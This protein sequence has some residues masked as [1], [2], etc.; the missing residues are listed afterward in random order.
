MTAE[1]EFFLRVAAFALG[2]IGLLAFFRSIVRKGWLNTRERDA[3]AMCVARIVVAA[4]VPVARRRRTYRDVQRLM[5]WAFPAYSFGLVI[6]WFLLV[7]S[8]FALMIRAVEADRTLFRAFIASGSALA[9][10]GFDS[11]TT[12]PGR[13]IAI[14]EGA[15]GLGIVV[16][17][18]TFIPGY[19]TA[20]Q[21]REDKVG[22]LYARAGPS[23]TAFNLIRWCWRA[24]KADDLTELWT[25]GE[26]W[27]RGIFE[28]HSV[29]PFLAF[30]PSIYE[31]GNWIR[32]AATLLDATSFAISSV[33]SPHVESARVCRAIGLDTL[34]SIASTL[35][36]GLPDEVLANTETLASDYD[37][38]YAALATGGVSLRPDRDQCR[39][40][41]L[42]LRAEY[43]S[44]MRHVA[45]ATLMPLD[46]N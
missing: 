2:S 11:P 4:F 17:L 26:T 25:T 23:P 10:L 18:F 40:Q 14:S 9:T 39:R 45:S 7:Q 27:F 6:F 13:L 5:A 19:Q 38:V 36:G 43:D 30:V 33:D 22:W 3:I 24:G 29:M 16:F 37:A 34:R 28:T 44:L 41:F 12:V 1:P 15:I 20:I 8:S 32:A 42:E 21:A 46:E 35:P 31:G